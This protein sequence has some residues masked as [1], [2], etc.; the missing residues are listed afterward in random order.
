M[1]YFQSAMPKV[2]ILAVV[3]I[4]GTFSLILVSEGSLRLIPSFIG[5]FKYRAEH[6]RQ[7]NLINITESEI[8]N[9][10]ERHIKIRDTFC[11]PN[12]TSETKV[13]KILHID[14]M[15]SCQP[16]NLTE[17]EKE[18]FGK[19]FKDMPIKK[20]RVTL[21][22]P[23]YSTNE[24]MIKDWKSNYFFTNNMTTL[25]QDCVNSRSRRRR[26]RS[27][28]PTTKELY[29]KNLQRK[30]NRDSVDAFVEGLNCYEKFLL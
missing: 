12:K 11:D 10:S 4:C 29:F 5:H 8:K 18:C 26:K 28:Q 13:M 15:T 7:N 19:V 14:N 16:T 6:W 22:Q 30:I 3:A 1:I 27:T 17:I 24:T 25:Y 20:W 2:V 21:C 9:I 23:Y